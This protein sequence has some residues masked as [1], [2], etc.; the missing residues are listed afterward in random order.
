[1]AACQWFCFE[2]TPSRRRVE[3]R[4]KFW[5]ATTSM[6]FRIAAGDRT[7]PGLTAA[8]TVM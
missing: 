3:F 1:M 6:C 4:S 2:S 5:L 7:I 8:P